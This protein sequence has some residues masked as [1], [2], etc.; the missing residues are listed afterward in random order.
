MQAISLQAD[1][2]E[3]NVEARSAGRKHNRLHAQKA[4]MEFPQLGRDAA[5]EG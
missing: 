3:A 1:V 4:L 2:R 5:S